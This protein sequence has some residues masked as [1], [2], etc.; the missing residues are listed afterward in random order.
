MVRV[1]FGEGGDPSGIMQERFGSVDLL[2]KIGV[3][4]P[5]AGDLQR[6]QTDQRESPTTGEH[7]GSNREIEHFE[8]P[9]I[10][11]KKQLELS[12]LWNPLMEF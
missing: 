2:S 6:L 8:A 11:E 4:T 5:F 7:G 10:D 12:H 1:R 3:L 9:G